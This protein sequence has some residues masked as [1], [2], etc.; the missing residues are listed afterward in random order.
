MVHG[1][2]PIV[3]N[4]STAAACLTQRADSFR[5]FH[6]SHPRKNGNRERT[7]GL[8]KPPTTHNAPYPAQGRT[9]RVPRK[10]RVAQK[11][12]RKKNPV[13]AVSHIQTMGKNRAVGRKTQTHEAPTATPS[14]N[15][16]LAMAWIG[17]IV[18]AA[19]AQFSVAM[20]MRDISL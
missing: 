15:V 3:N 10:A 18:R 13:R 7:E 6:T 16:L 2:R 1:T 20:M 14:P 19:K 11:I 4:R 17:I 8:I 12:S 5:S 9:L